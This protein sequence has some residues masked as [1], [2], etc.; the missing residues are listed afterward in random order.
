MNNALLYSARQSIPL[1]SRLGNRVRS[2]GLGAKPPYMY[3]QFGLCHL[4]ILEST[5]L[6]KECQVAAP[7]PSRPLGW[8]WCPLAPGLGS[9]FGWLAW[10]R[11]RWGWL[12]VWL[13]GFVAP[14]PSRP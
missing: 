11:W 8:V 5:R 12:G 13:A 14:W 1:S 9:G 6:K 3:E 10:V 2:F 4:S 7:S